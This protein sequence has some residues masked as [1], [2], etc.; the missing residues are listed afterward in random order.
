M[1]ILNI[2]G[3][4]TNANINR[5]LINWDRSVSGPQFATKNFLK[6]Y[7]SHHIVLE[8]FRIP[9]S[10][11]RVDLLCIDLKIAIEVS[12]TSTHSTYNPFFHGSMAG[13]RSSIKRD[14]IKQQWCEKNAFKFVEITDQDMPLTTQWFLEKYDIIL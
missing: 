3:R 9:S 2:Y 7:W 5:Y 1:K 11:L 12:P 13:Y 4:E 14:L 8:E 6:P 10:R